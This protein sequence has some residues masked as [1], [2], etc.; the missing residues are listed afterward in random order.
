VA[1]RSKAW[2]CGRWFAGIAD[3]YP[4]GGMAVIPLRVW[5][6]VKYGPL[7]RTDHSSRGVIPSVVYLSAIVM[8][9]Y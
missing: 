4:A 8:N 9:R 5:C 6:V 2:V 3:S 1:T 7:R